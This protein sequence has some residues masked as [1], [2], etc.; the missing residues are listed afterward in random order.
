MTTTED[1]RNCI[2]TLSDVERLHTRIV[3]RLPN[4]EHSYQEGLIVNLAKLGI[5]LA[6][7][8]L[9]IRENIDNTMKELDK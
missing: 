2:N 1:L 4:P 8:L 6:K 7:E 3:H 5:K 9:A